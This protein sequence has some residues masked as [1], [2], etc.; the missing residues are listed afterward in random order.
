VT[1]RRIAT[2]ASTIVVAIVVALAVPVSQLRTFSIVASCCCPD[3]SHCHCPD[4]D[5][6]KGD[7][8][9][10][11][12]ACHKTSHEVVSPDAPAV[13]MPQLAIATEAPRATPRVAWM[14]AEPHAAPAPARPDAPS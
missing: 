7:D 14:I 10:S 2:A 8:R 13:A 3:P 5:A 1:L 11:M 4:H 9:G 12:R 6:G